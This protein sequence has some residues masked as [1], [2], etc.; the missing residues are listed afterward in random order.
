MAERSK[1][2]ESGKN[3]TEK[4]VYLVFRGEGSNPSSVNNLF[5]GLFLILLYR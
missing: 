2:P 3:F 1:A 5:I 4:F